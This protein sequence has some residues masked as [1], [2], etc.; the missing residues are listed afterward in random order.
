M[1]LAVQ[2]WE[3]AGVWVVRI[4]IAGSGSGH[5]ET[6]INQTKMIARLGRPRGGLLAYVETKEPNSI[7]WLVLNTAIKLN[8]ASCEDLS[9]GSSIR[10]GSGIGAVL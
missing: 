6:T 9:R 5:K 1:A 4:Y 10:D 7:Q 8:E 2:A 3:E